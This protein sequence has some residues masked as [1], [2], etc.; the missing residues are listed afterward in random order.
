MG[1]KAF[2]TLHACKKMFGYK[3]GLTTENY[4]LKVR[5]GNKAYTYIRIGGMAKVKTDTTALRTET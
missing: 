5:R 3:W 1:K 2:C 4:T